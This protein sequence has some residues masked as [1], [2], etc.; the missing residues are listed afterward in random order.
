MPDI[1][2][3]WQNSGNDTVN[4]EQDVKDDWGWRII[5]ETTSQ[6]LDLYLKFLLIM[7]HWPYK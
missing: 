4:Y 7:K 2:I 1:C 5:T 6:L 3:I